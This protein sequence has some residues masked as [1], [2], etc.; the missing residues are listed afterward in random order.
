MQPN[1]Q[2]SGTKPVMFH[3]GT[4]S[5]SGTVLREVSFNDVDEW[6]TSGKHPL[7]C[8]TPSLVFKRKLHC[9][10]PPINV[11]S[12]FSCDESE[13]PLPVTESTT[14]DLICKSW[15]HGMLQKSKQ[16]VTQTPKIETLQQIE[17]HTKNSD[18]QLRQERCQTCSSTEFVSGQPHLKKLKRR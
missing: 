7:L 5:H 16:C 13:K 4:N 17:E 8:S 12:S 2:K 3:S 11:I 14:R 15:K 1:S 18:A 9:L 10:E 6:M